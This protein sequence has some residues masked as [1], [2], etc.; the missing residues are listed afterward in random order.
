M[1]LTMSNQPMPTI[2]LLFIIKGMFVPVVTE[3]L[4]YFIMLY[5]VLLVALFVTV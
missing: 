1:P 5:T 2:Q 4:V 3:A